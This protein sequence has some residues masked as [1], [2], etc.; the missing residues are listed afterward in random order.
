MGA[1]YQKCCQNQ[2]SHTNV[3]KCW[4]QWCLFGCNLNEYRVK[5]E[6]SQRGTKCLQIP[7]EVNSKHKAETKAHSS[8]VPSGLNVPHQEKWLADPQAKISCQQSWHPFLPLKFGP[9]FSSH[10][11]NLQMYYRRHQGP[12]KTTVRLKIHQPFVSKSAF[13][14]HE[15]LNSQVRFQLSGSGPLP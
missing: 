4:R 7:F 12:S 9:K 11:V 15:K 2:T 10:C 1:A 14:N 6:R 13:K 3:N 8:R 5:G